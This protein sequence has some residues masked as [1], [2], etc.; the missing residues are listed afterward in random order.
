MD[1]SVFDQFDD[2]DHVVVGAP[3]VAPNDPFVHFDNDPPGD[4]NAKIEPSIEPVRPL[5]QSNPILDGVPGLTLDSDPVIANK[6]TEL[7]AQ[8]KKQGTDAVNEARGNSFLEGI[9]DRQQYLEVGKGVPG[10][11]VKFV[12]TTL[13]GG[14][15]AQQHAAESYKLFLQQQIQVMDK[16]DRGEPVRPIDDLYDYANLSPEEKQAA[17][18]DAERAATGFTPTPL[19][20]R[21]LMQA[22]QSVSEYGSTILP[23]A[24]GYENAVGR[25]L[26]EGLGSMVAGL[27][28]GVVGRA[29]ALLFFSAGGSGEAI[30]RA[31]DFDR[32]ER[33]AGREG[34][35]DAQIAQA[36]LLGTVPGSTDVAPVELLLGRLKIPV[37]VRGVLAKVITKIGGQAL[38]EGLQESGQ[39]FLQNLI[40]KEQYD[41][42][43]A[44]SENIAPEGEMGAGVG[45][46]AA[47]AEQ[48]AHALLKAFVGHRAK[49]KT[50]REPFPGDVLPVAQPETGETPSPATSAPE[51]DTSVFTPR[52]EKPEG[53]QGV[54]VLQFIKNK[55]GIQPS[56]ELDAVDA[57][58]YPGLVSQKGLPADKMREALVEAGYLEEA[59]PD[60]PAVTTPQDVY[61]LVAKSIGGEKVVAI[62]DQA[63]VQSQRDQEEAY[64]ADREL[65]AAEKN[66]VLPEIAKYDAEAGSPVLGEAYKVLTNDEKAEVIDRNRRGEDVSDLIEEIAMRDQE[67]ASTTARAPLAPEATAAQETVAGR[68]EEQRAAIAPMA[69]KKQTGEE[70]FT[71]EQ[72]LFRAAWDGPVQS[73]D[74]LVNHGF[75]GEAPA[76]VRRAGDFTGPVRQAFDDLIG[77]YKDIVAAYAAGDRNAA[78]AAL[79]KAVANASKLDQLEDSPKARLFTQHARFM[80][81]NLLT[82]A[83]KPKLSPMAIASAPETFPGQGNVALT[84]EAQAKYPALQAAVDRAAA[85]ILPDDVRIDVVDN[86]KIA[87]LRKE[88]ELLALREM[89]AVTQTPQFKRWF[90]G[91]TVTDE[92]GKPLVVYHGTKADFSVFDKAKQRVSNSFFFSR[93]PSIPN[94]YAREAGGT[95]G[96]VMPVYLRIEKPAPDYAAYARDDGTLYDGLEEAGI[97]Q[98]R[99]PNQIKSAIGNRGTFDPTDPRITYALRKSPLQTNPDQSASVE[100]SEEGGVSGSAENR[101][102]AGGKSN[103][104]VSGRSEAG[105]SAGASE[106]VSTA[107]PEGSDARILRTESG[108]F[109]PDGSVIRGRVSRS[110]EGTEVGTR[111]EGESQKVGAT[112]PFDIG[113]FAGFVTAEQPMSEQELRDIRV[114]ADRAKIAQLRYR[115]YPKGTEAAKNMRSLGKPA[116]TAT[117]GQHQDG[118]W[119]VQY[120]QTD[121]A[122]ARRRLATKL[123]KAIETDL[124]IRMSPSGM[125]TSEGFK[126]WQQR[127]PASVQYHVWSPVDA[128]YVSPNWIDRRLSDVGREIGDISRRAV[129]RPLDEIDLR[130]L[131]D[132]RGRLIKMWGKLP[133][134][135]R[136]AKDSMFALRA[137]HGSPHD[138]DRFSMDKIGTGEGAQVFGH[139]LYFA[140]NQAVAS[141]YKELLSSYTIDGQPIN[142]VLTESFAK[143]KVEGRLDQLEADYKAR[144]QDILKN[145][146]SDAEALFL[147]PDQVQART[148]VA[149][150]HVDDSLAKIAEIRKADVKRGGS[151]YEVALDV[152]P[153]QL[154]DWDK[155]LSEQSENIRRLSDLDEFGYPPESIT[156]QA[157]LSR[158]LDPPDGPPPGKEA[159]SEL[160]RKVGI[161]GIRYLDQGSRTD[162]VRYKGASIDRGNAPLVE[163]GR[164]LEIYQTPKDALRALKDNAK[165]NE[166]AAS[167][168][169]EIAAYLNSGD[170]AMSGGTHNFVL[171]DDSLVKI[172]HKNGEPVTAQERSDALEQMHES[173]D[174]K[175]QMLSLRG[176][177]QPGGFDPT[178]PRTPTEVKVYHGTGAEMEKFDP[179]FFGF[180]TQARKPGEKPNRTTEKAF[181]FSDD[182]KLAEPYAE[183]ITNAPYELRAAA[184][185]SGFAE[186]DDPTAFD[187]LKRYNP[188]IVEE[189]MKALEEQYHVSGA[190]MFPAFIE[191]KN[192]KNV[193]MKGY[194][195]NSDEGAKLRTQISKAKKEGKSGLVIDGMED[196]GGSTARQY[197]V[198]DK[199]TVRSALSDAQLFAMRQRQSE[200]QA[201][202]RTD[203]YNMLISIGAEAVEAEAKMK[204][205]TAEEEAVRV[206]RHEAV[207]FFKATGVFSPK[208]WQLLERTAKSKGWVE[209]T[210][211]RDAYTQLYQSGMSEAELNQLLIKEAI[212]EQYS[213]YHF[214]RKEFTPAIT[215]IFA[216]IKALLT[217]LMNGVRGRGFDTWDSIFEKIDAGEFK[218]RYERL[219]GKSEEAAQGGQESAV[220]PA[221]RSGQL[222]EARGFTPAPGASGPVTGMAEHIDALKTALGMTVRQGR[223]DPA[224]KRAMKQAGGGDVVGQFSHATGVT[225]LTISNDIDT[226]S[227]EGGHHLEA[228]FGRGLDAI[229]TQFASELTPLASPGPDQLSEGF[230]EFFRRYVTNPDAAKQRAPQFFKS[231]E[232]SLADNDKAMLDS[233]QALQKD[234]DAFLKGD[235]TEVKIA[236]QTVLKSTDNAFTEFM[237]DAEKT[238]LV[239]T[240]GDRL[241]ALYFNMIA[242]NHGWWLA[243]KRMLDLIETNTGKR[244]D[245]QAID[246]PNKLLRRIS[247]TAAWAMQDLKRGV[248]TKARPNGGGA[249][250]HEALA[251]AFGGT[252]KKQWDERAVQEFGDYLISRRA[253]N[254]YVKFKPA[255]RKDVEAF[256]KANPTLQ[257]LLPRLPQNKESELANAPTL[258]PLALHLQSVLDHEK[259]NPQLR[260]AAGI[261]YQFNKD[262]LMLLEE[263]GLLGTDER[264]RLLL[265]N[266]Y[267]PFQRDMSDR[268]LASG[269]Q[270]SRRGGQSAAQA[271]KFSVYKSIKGST[272]DIINP[273]QSTVQFVYEM[274][275]RAALNDTLVAMD[276]LAKAAGTG[277][278]AIFER[279]P[280]REAKGYNVQIQEALKQA[281]KDAGMSDQDTT[282]MLGN[283]EQFLGKNAATMLFTQQQANEKGERIVW[284]YQD[285]KPVPARIADGTLGDMMFEGF[286]TMGKRSADLWMKIL[287]LPAQAVRTGVTFSFEFV[288][289][290]F[291]IDSLAAPVNSPYALPFITQISGAKE[292]LSGGKYQQLYN[293]TAGMMG[294]EM[295]ASISDQSIERDIKAL[296]NQGFQVRRPR[297]IGEFAKMVFQLGEFSETATRVGVFKAAMKSAKSDGLSDFDAAAEAAHAAHDVIDFSRAGSKT[298]LLRRA[299]P[300]FNASLQGVDKY[301]RTLTAQGDHGSAITTWLKYRDGQALTKSEKAAL[302][303]AGKAWALTTM[304]MGGM[305]F[306]FYMLGQDDDDLDEISDRLRATHWRVSLNGVIHLIPKDLRTFLGV[307]EK[308]DVQ[309]RLPKPFEIAWFANAVERALDAAKKGD[310]T[311]FNGYLNDFWEGVKPPDGIPLIDIP[312]GFMTGKDL[313]SGRDTIPIWEKDLARKEQFG[314][315]TTESA[316]WIGK[317]LNVSP[318]YVDQ[319]VRGVGAS[320][321]RD[322]QTGID[323]AVG[324]GPTPGIEE[325]PIARRFTY[326]TA[327]SSKSIQKFYDM[328]SDRESLNSWFWD[329]VSTDARSFAAAK[330]TYK[331]FKDNDNQAAAG[332]F[333]ESLNPNQKVMAILGVD[334]KDSKSK[335]RNLHP[336]ENASEGVSATN[337]LM[338]EIVD[339]VMLAGKK[340]ERVPLDRNQMQFA[341]N[342]LG[343]IRKGIAQNALNIIGVPG[344]G[345]Q[346]MMDVDARLETLKA[347]AP[348]VYDEL[349][350]RLNKKGYIDMKHLKEVWPEVKERVL[351]DKEQAQLSDLYSGGKVEKSFEAAR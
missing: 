226:L 340:E 251:M 64:Q 213:E 186:G 165:R 198:W 44:L 21:S 322:V 293:R 289:R 317:L 243:T 54:D 179:D 19:N 93:S 231:F 200:P 131:R 330:A 321:G 127:S 156:G 284:F 100:P 172:T 258:E 9:G 175:D 298:E 53:S 205:V 310:P 82:E 319:I 68:T 348:A 49:M 29:P 305:S 257:Y 38:A 155:P 66:F 6:L 95:G 283:V 31:M 201:L 33:A 217:R 167:N 166:F 176:R 187:S 182:P 67:A 288:F 230:A 191:T 97:Y 103:A 212:A 118:A 51:A 140:E 129:I 207:E 332:D 342:E 335:Y 36:G 79:N 270:A 331:K 316:K 235:P 77:D 303:Q 62:N 98:V 185:K 65:Q 83:P 11:A 301:V 148:R 151:L 144:R 180:R 116:V 311:A 344:W 108:T 281:A 52:V 168:E 169:K 202:G 119:E 121:E 113:G 99:D 223:L 50:A 37:P 122:Q 233:L 204:G 183:N 248:A 323:F 115:V 84:E 259:R 268:E 75:E 329:T 145:S 333:Y 101:A 39:S 7:D 137:F 22:G 161:P 177:A 162:L 117:V 48:A 261:Y 134:E 34:L 278:G 222:A 312:Y 334:F 345:N 114:P 81:K 12:G 90:G 10:G 74:D 125:L 315:Y 314:P 341:R 42:K 252:G 190:R 238:G 30:E 254:L 135:A 126:F 232:A 339:G 193:D 269:S 110:A 138:F 218:A 17:R 160:M 80:A 139:G 61:D 295:S 59:G 299:I 250:L 128:H 171:F 285:G 3:Q 290:N 229:K 225:R 203:P 343:H 18:A 111:A 157:L 264:N 91:S 306:L 76:A 106:G 154:L 92:Q 136:A 78:T 88:D 94:A 275:L 150:N 35:T 58:R 220:A 102:A 123:Y 87:R 164:L 239:D 338:K 214:G 60:Q 267:A 255:L 146:P 237:K 292:I 24:P 141:Q 13:K 221:V 336:I 153:H 197:A 20:Q 236:N 346:K 246:N 56:G 300:F 112:E 43:Q 245:L 47:T 347:G 318:Y 276:K 308:T 159:V 14:A 107:G 184:I 26:G 351:Q 337:G 208:E 23:A 45:A 15:A 260:Q 256:I 273:I 215:R 28:L 313:F 174:Q 279:L 196:A 242:K 263:K 2:D 41:P 326:N 120:V 241:H 57:K 219:F 350:R 173:Q 8:I 286:S 294:G 210:G 143:A 149:L 304:V 199:G 1:K 272:R 124:G 189:K 302:G 130:F 132:E 282:Y 27:P 25:Q 46:I 291:L 69:A 209:S 234:Y 142:D 274:R 253:I 206:L 192:F 96:N 277:S 104:A 320:V 158:L 249:S 63:G 244:V 327:R 227:H 73:I 307:P 178:K 309:M 105:V 240:I 181:F 133:E 296:R 271:N 224:L 266:D 297:T 85:K 4:W 262:V 325:Y 324:K 211:V 70:G 16:I 228:K 287:G 328:L 55:G 109:R 280:P 194:R 349:N 216:R 32:T 86:I 170:L 152:E 195:W 5:Q 188:K 163:A 71:Q 147:S 40:A 247:H 265:D 72:H 89:R